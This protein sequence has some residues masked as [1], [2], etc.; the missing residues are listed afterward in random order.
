MDIFK[1]YN[2]HGAWSSAMGRQPIGTIETIVS[3]FEAQVGDRVDDF[4]FASESG[5]L[6]MYFPKGKVIS[7][8][9]KVGTFTE[10]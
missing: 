8:L 4:D 6:S 2:G 7:I 10:V 3:F 1:A 5:E 9:V